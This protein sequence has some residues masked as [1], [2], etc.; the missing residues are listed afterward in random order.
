MSSEWKERWLSR[1]DG[2]QLAWSLGA[3]VIRPTTT[4]KIPVRAV[5]DPMVRIR[6]VRY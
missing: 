2:S 6:K 3:Q 1:A 4:L 5:S